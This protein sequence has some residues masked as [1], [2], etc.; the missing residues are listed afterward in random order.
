MDD[1]R[2]DKLARQELGHIEDRFMDVDP[3]EVEVSTSD[4]VLHLDLRGGIRIVINAHRA[5]KQIWMAAVT[6]AWHFDYIENEG[7][8]RSAKGGVVCELRETLASIIKQR[9]G[10]EMENLERQSV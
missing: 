10:L 7:I 4:G 3:D 2:F 5:A 9:V 8:W 1:T 6:D